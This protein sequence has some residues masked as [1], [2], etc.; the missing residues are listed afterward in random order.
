MRWIKINNCKEHNLKGVSVQIPKEQLTVICGVS[1]SGKSS[2][3]FDTLFAEGQ[4]RYIESLSSYAK[5]F[6]GVLK[7]PDVESIDG[8]SPAIA[9]NQKKLS[10]NPRSTVATVT[11]IYDYLRLFFNYLGTP[12]CPKCNSLIEKQTSQEI[13][14]KIL[15]LDGEK[16]MITSP[17]IRNKKGEYRQVFAQIKR[18]GFSRVIVDGIVYELDE[19]IDIDKNKRHNI[20][21]VVDR[22]KV[23]QKDKS[24]IASSVELALSKS[25]GYIKLILP[26]KDQTVDYNENLICGKCG[27]NFPEI[28]PA[29]FSFNSI[30]GICDQC[31][32]LGYEVGVDEDKIFNKDL[33]I[34]QGGIIPIELLGRYYKFLLPEVLKRNRIDPTRKIGKLPKKHIKLLLDGTKDR[35]YAIEYYSADG[36]LWNFDAKYRGLTSAL[37]RKLHHRDES[38]AESEPAKQLRDIVLYKPCSDCHGARISKYGR[39]IRVKDLNI[40]DITRMSVKD[41]KYLFETIE[42]DEYQRKIARRIIEEVTNRLEFISRVGLDYLT[43]DRLA[44]TLSGGES[45][46]IHLAGQLGSSLSGVS[47]VLD[48]PSIGLHPKDNNKLITMLKSLKENGNTVVVVEHDEETIDNADYIIELGPRGGTEGGELMYQGDV[49]AMKAGNTLTGQYLSR[50]REIVTL[51]K[52]T[53]F[54]DYITIKSAT[55]NNLRSVDATI[56]LGGFTVI[57]GIS[58]SGKSSLME[59]V[60]YKGLKKALNYGVTQSRFYSDIENFQKVQRLNYIDQSPIGRTP[61]SNPATYTKLFDKIRELFSLT[62]EARKRGYKKGRFSFNV[63]GG[64]CEKCRGAG[65]QKLEMSFLP[66]VYVKCDVC[67][68]K[69]F[70]EETLEVK[71]KGYSIYD[72]LN[73]TIK[74]AHDV[75]KNIPDMNKKLSILMDLG[76]DYLTLGQSSTTISGGEAQR[77]K[78]AS[79]LWRQSKKTL[80]LMDEPT[81][82]LH[83][84][85]IDKL[86]RV[87]EA[88]KKKGHTIVMIEHNLDIIKNSDYIIDMGPDAGENGGNVVYQGILNGIFKKKKSY[89]GQYLKEH[90]DKSLESATESTTGENLEKAT[91]SKK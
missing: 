68:G 55:A 64:R 47:Y 41:A 6:L 91:K 83:F 80:Y 35:Q 87:I 69:R 23:K 59:E 77:I 39:S 33:S 46:R 56:P 2:L 89:T 44:R 50:K 42:L 84:S 58:G 81:T 4:R 21:I 60:I 5:Q 20:E 71:Y 29:L 25:K 70:N 43:L 82:G 86:L 48:E 17:I 78:L 54:D 53:K 90:L 79:E 12:Y 65:I 62:E 45:Q 34:D 26:D 73:L 37:A 28:T 74:E 66:D 30:I 67:Q 16:V 32:G 1:G 38:E 63:K 40:H 19:K 13:I 57:T 27:E 52:T 61:R 72:I 18:E 76:V 36:R 85:E 75:F 11:E 9:I 31:K 7:K 24:R 88:L 8:L 51:P 15:Q 10:S 49:T 3:A 22:I 14:E